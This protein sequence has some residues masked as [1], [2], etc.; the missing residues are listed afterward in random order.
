MGFS[1][2]ELIFRDLKSQYQQIVILAKAGIHKV[3]EECY[4]VHDGSPHAR[5]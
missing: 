2:K 4:A 3:L 1:Q 5:G